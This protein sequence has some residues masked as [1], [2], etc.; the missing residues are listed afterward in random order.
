MKESINARIKKV[1]GS[2]S[3]TVFGEMVGATR[4]Q[5]AFAEGEGHAVSTILVK[6]ICLS[7]RI[8]EQWMLHGLGDQTIS[9][10]KSIQEQKEDIVI[11]YQEQKEDIVIE[12]IESVLNELSESN[13]R[14]VLGAV[15][16]MKILDKKISEKNNQ[17]GPD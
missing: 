10:E 11:E 12:Y 7:C 6:A 14:I 9:E 8:N 3:Q 13:L 2:L 5:I 16:R 1:R 4:N 15:Q 17:S